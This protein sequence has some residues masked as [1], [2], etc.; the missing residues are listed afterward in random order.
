MGQPFL[1][2]L[3][4]LRKLLVLGTFPHFEAVGI[5]YLRVIVDYLKVDKTPFFEV[6]V[7]EECVGF[8]FLVKA[9]QIESVGLGQE[10]FVNA[11]SAHDEDFVLIGRHLQGLW[12]GRGKFIAF[13]SFVESVGDD[14]VATVGQG[15]LSWQR[16]PSV[17]AHND[18]MP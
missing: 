2:L 6:D 1:V 16:E 14:D 3:F 4:V 18:T 17:V 15:L 8:K 10:L 13:R 11:A 9:R 7:G 12:D 5:V